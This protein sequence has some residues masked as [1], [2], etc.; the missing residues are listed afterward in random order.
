MSDH[1]RASRFSRLLARAYPR[2]LRA[3]YAE[4]I[5]RF[6]DDRRQDPQFANRPFSRIRLGASLVADAT[7]TVAQSLLHHGAHSDGAQCHQ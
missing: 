7:R 3:Q 4:D 2:D 5:A 6:I 1:P